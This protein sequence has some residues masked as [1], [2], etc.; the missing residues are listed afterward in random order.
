MAVRRAATRYAAAVMMMPA[1]ERERVVAAVLARN[2]AESRNAANGLETCWRCAGG[3]AAGAE[4]CPECGT[5][6]LAF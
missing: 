2:A 6:T 4:R 5:D 3:H 1:A